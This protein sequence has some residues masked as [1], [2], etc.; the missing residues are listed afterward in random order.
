MI[1]WF[2]TF[3][4]GRGDIGIR[5]R[6]C[7]SKVSHNFIRNLDDPRAVKSSL[8]NLNR[9]I[10]FHSDAS[11]ECISQR[12]VSRI[13]SPLRAKESSIN[14]VKAC[15]H[16]KKRGWSGKKGGGW[17]ELKSLRHTRSGDVQR[18]MGCASWMGRLGRVAICM[19]HATP[20]PPPPAAENEAERSGRKG[21]ETR[22]IGNSS[23]FL[24]L[25]RSRRIR[26]S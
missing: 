18:Y 14:T 3:E 16:P 6:K 21:R 10:Q 13:N 1:L 17:G 7:Q 15:R 26:N 23:N 19:L 24:S 25:P 5:S 12:R 9:E 11:E 22:E 8:Q 20:P 4:L 2:I